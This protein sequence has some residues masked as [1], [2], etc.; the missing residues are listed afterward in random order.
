[1]NS[2]GLEGKVSAPAIVRTNPLLRKYDE[3]FTRRSGRPACVEE[4]GFFVYREL[5]NELVL[6][7]WPF[8]WRDV[9]GVV[10]ERYQGSPDS[11]LS[12]FLESCTRLLPERVLTYDLVTPELSVELWNGTDPVVVMSGSCDSLVCDSHAIVLG[13]A[14]T[15]YASDLTIIFSEYPVGWLRRGRLLMREGCRTLLPT[16][17]SG[18]GGRNSDYVLVASELNALGFGNENKVYHPD[19]N[20]VLRAAYDRALRLDPRSPTIGTEMDAILTEFRRFHYS[21]SIKQRGASR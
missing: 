19:I 15:V 11:V 21:P 4:D 10:Q 5:V 3:E 7:F 14:Q 8:S 20:P 17:C 12:V 13:D 16:P 1:M 6:S 18:T 9:L 2:F